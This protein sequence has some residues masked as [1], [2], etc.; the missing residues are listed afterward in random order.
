MENITILTPD[1]KLGFVGAG[2]MARAIVEGILREKL[3][4]PSHI[5]ISHPSAIENRKFADLEIDNE[6]ADN[7][8]VV[9]NSDII[10]LCVKPQILKKVC[11]SLRD[12][13]DFERHFIVSVVAG[14]SLEKIT[15][16][17]I[18]PNED[19]SIFLLYFIYFG[20]LILISS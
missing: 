11:E 19:V 8:F 20:G 9:Q 17:I 15:E 14:I 10:L 3:C 13:I 12:S 7:N 16:Y 1:V 18:P 5:Y 2:N 6:V 4:R